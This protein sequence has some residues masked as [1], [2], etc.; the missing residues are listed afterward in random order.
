M[1]ATLKI[2]H[3]EDDANDAELVEETLRGAELNDE[4]TR[5][6]NRTEFLAALDG[7]AWDL[8][9]ADYALPSFDGLSALSIVRKRE[10]E[11]P[12]IFVTGTMGEA[13]AVEALKRGA[14]DYVLKTSL[15]RLPSVVQRA[16]QEATDRRRRRAAEE[17]LST[18]EIRYRRLFETAQ[19]GILLL[20]AETGVITEAN[21]FLLKLLRYT[22]EEI[23]GKK[24][25]EIGA[26]LD[27]VASQDAFR[28]LQARG[29]VRYE[30]I[31]LETKTGETKAVEFI[32]NTY[33]AGD[34]TV[35]Q[36]NVRDIT[37]RTR[38]EAE[39]ARLVTAIEQ[40]G[41]GVMITNTTGDIEYVNPA[42]TRITGYALEEV[43][44]RNPRILKS[45]KQ[46]PT[47]YQRLWAT[48]LKGEIWHGELVNRR[49]DGKLYTEEMNIAPVRDSRGDITHFIATKHDVTERKHLEDQ[50]RQAQKMEAV[51]RLAG[52]VAH[53]FNNLLTV[54]NG[55]SDM[56]LDRV[57]GSDPTRGPVEEIRRAG[58]RAASLTRQLLAF[59][60]QQV[61]EPKVL[62]LNEL[63][64]DGEEMLR[65][66]IGEDIDLAV[67]RAS[68]LGRVKADPGQIFQILMN[69]A[70]NARDAMPQGGK[71]TIE[72]S[73][74]EFDEARAQRHPIAPGRYVMLAVSD[75]G[76]GM[77]ADTQ[78]RMFEP[79]FT[80]KE[81]GK[82]TGLG[83]AMVYGT[84]KQSGGFIWVYSE[85][86]RG[87]T[88]KIHL[89]R[90]EEVHELVR[91][92]QPQRHSSAGTETVLLLEDE[93][94]VRTLASVI[95]QSSGYKVLESRSPEDALRIGEQCKEPI[96]LLLTDMV[97]PRM[98]GRQVAEHLASLRPALRVIFMSGYTDNALVHDGALEARSAFL[99]KPFTPLALA[100]KV[101]EVL[102]PDGTKSS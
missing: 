101:R 19:D 51:G 23:V 70:V 6:Q 92:S 25:W 40:S 36:C 75:T 56:L 68:R 62:D 16:L 95:L 5:V 50:L 28:N 98:S 66:L 67:V 82:G 11:T 42:F 80:T 43:L 27:V 72:T 29:F 47:L 74:V 84:V 100:R 1:D 30:N 61:L 20:D 49:K 54:I 90:V 32:S 59:S 85:P 38:A 22:A 46:D 77:D 58:D 91:T 12:F 10:L 64:A 76:V 15:P 86:G 14:T 63:V 60:R 57:T 87:T 37:E 48:I 89:P 96:D 34:K 52:G 45:G 9:L 13:T 94:A 88:L 24:L 69:L 65:R 31:P 2:L 26:I 4:I 44:G 7:G 99:Q 18:S 102:D 21:P 81:K 71:L 83:L 39:N 3:L 17:A 8:I 33:W 55:Y 93:E 78:A 53:D 73:D 41:E 35:I 97:M 79:F